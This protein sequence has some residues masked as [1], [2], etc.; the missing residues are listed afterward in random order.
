MDWTQWGPWLGLAAL[1]AFHG[2]NPAMGWLFAVALGLQ[3][4][5]ADAVLLALVPIAVGHAASLAVVAAALLLLGAA[6]PLLWW[7]LVVGSVLLAAGA[8]KLLRPSAHPRWVGMRVGVA[9]LFAWSFLMA[10]SHGAGLM[11]APVLAAL[12]N[13]ATA[14]DSH[15]KLLG[16]AASPQVWALG[17][18]VHTAAMLLVMLPIALAVYAWVGLSFLRW[19][20]LN[21]DLV[22]AVALLAAG[23]YTLL[24]ALG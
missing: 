3:R 17:L 20:W 6:V 9:G 13:G 1:G 8:Y 22:W 2:L 16:P 14:A 15:G 24:A 7:R 4:G 5:R 10:T 21:A 19:G 18:G 12:R 23:A 11:L